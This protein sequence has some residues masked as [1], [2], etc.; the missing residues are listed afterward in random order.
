MK[1]QFKILSGIPTS[2]K[3][4]YCNQY[5]KDFA[6]LSRDGI[7][8]L[9]YGKKYKQNNESEKRITK[10]FNNAL[11]TLLEDGKNIIIDNT[12]VKEVYINQFLKVISGYSNYEV[13]IIFFDIP[14]W[15]AKYRN[16]VRKIR[17]GK[18]IPIKVLNQMYSS[19]T[20]IDRSKY[21]KILKLTNN[22]T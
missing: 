13:E 15:K 12:N 21:Q 17:T 9:L 16:I 14:L 5:V 18:W 4:T 3:S 11:N 2:G 22:E 10:V 20:Q 6:I 7:R 8:E 19:Y 1:P